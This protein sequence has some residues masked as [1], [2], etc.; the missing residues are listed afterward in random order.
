MLPLCQIGHMFSNKPVWQGRAFKPTAH[1]YIGHDS[2]TAC[3]MIFNDD[4]GDF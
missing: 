1:G 4:E 2:C 3:D